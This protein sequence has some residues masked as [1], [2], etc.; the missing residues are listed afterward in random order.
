MIFFFLLTGPGAVASS[1]DAWCD[2]PNGWS[3][4]LPYIYYNLNSAANLT[5]HGGANIT[6]DGYV[7]ITVLPDDRFQM[8]R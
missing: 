6:E 3:G 5:L 1:P 2:E 7:S 8:C 4:P